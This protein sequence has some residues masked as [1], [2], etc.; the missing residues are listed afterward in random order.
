MRRIV[1]VTQVVDPED[2]NL[3]A[4]TAAFDR[5]TATQVGTFPNPQDFRGNPSLTSIYADRQLLGLGAG[6]CCG[7]QARLFASR[8]GARSDAA[9]SVVR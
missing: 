2:P 6:G 9:G 7:F 8:S 1:F 3:G 4:V 5:R